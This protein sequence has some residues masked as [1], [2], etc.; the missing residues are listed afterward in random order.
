MIAMLYELLNQSENYAYHESRFRLGL[1]L[2]SLHRH[3][4][5]RRPRLTRS[6][7]PAAHDRLRDLLWQARRI[8]L[9]D[10]E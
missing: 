8:E 9:H 3:R 6:W 7:R 2:S 4:R 5:C 10:I 1:R